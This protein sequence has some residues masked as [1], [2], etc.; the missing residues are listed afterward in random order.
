MNTVGRTVNY[1]K[2]YLEVSWAIIS[3]K[4]IKRS[5]CFFDKL[6]PLLE[7]SLRKWAKSYTQENSFVIVKSYISLKVH[8]ENGG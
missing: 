2:T 6:I 4:I 5:A 3:V 7:Y 8:Q 1:I